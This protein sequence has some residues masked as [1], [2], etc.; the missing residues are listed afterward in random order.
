MKIKSFEISKS[1][2]TKR[3]YMLYEIDSNK[4]WSIKG[5]ID[6]T[7][8]NDFDKNILESCDE[9]ISSEDNNSTSVMS[10]LTSASMT[11]EEQ[12]N[13]LKM[14]YAI[15][16]IAGNVILYERTPIKED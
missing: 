5:M 1:V 7:Q 15:I 6:Q 16:P 11:E 4:V 10:L 2:E 8:V 9:F 14:T 13:V 3:M 12:L